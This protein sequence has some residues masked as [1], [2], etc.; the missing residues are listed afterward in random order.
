MDVVA[1]P[2]VNDCDRAVA[3]VRRQNIPVR[4]ISAEL[5][6]VAALAIKARTLAV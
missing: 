5:P 4:T 2:I 6:K 1:D 3:F